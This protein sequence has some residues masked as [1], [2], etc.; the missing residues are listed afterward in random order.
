MSLFSPYAS[1]YYALKPI[2]HLLTVSLVLVSMIL[3]S[4]MAVV[5]SWGWLLFTVTML[6]IHALRMRIMSFWVRE[7][8][9]Q[10]AT[11][12]GVYSVVSGSKDDNMK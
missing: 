8:R 1:R 12:D 9:N 4:I 11:I 2:P 7:P 3:G 5:L 10:P 6:M